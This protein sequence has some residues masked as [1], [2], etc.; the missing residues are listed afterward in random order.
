VRSFLD[1]AYSQHRENIIFAFGEL[2]NIPELQ[3]PKFVFVHILA[4][5]EPFV[6]GAQGELVGRNTPFSLNNDWDTKNL[7]SYRHGY[8][9]QVNYVNLR[10]LRAVQEIIARSATPPII[11]LQGDHGTL[12]RVSSQNAR[13]TILNAYYLPGGGEE[14]LYGTITP[15][16]TFRLILDYYFGANLGLFSDSSYYYDEYSQSY[17]LVTN[18]RKLCEVPAD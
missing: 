5:H 15:V 7:E 13:M 4:P 17:P 16:N 3:S 2:E 1:A 9:D 12:A 6:F 18:K 11:I 14:L 8:R 10:I